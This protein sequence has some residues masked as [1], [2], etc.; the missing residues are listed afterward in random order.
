MDHTTDHSTDHTTTSAATR[1][2]RRPP[3]GGFA[4]AAVDIDDTLLG[5]D[6]LISAENAAAVRQLRERGVHVVLASGRSHA[7]MRPFHDALGLGDGPIISAQGA[8]VRP[9]AG[10]A[11]WLEQVLDAAL[12]ERVT[13]QGIERGFAVQHYRGDE[14]V[15]QGRTRWTEFDQALNDTAQQVVEDLLGEPFTGVEKVIW[16]GEPAD[17]AAA[18]AELAPVYEGRMTV[19]VTHSAYLEFYDPRTSKA[20]GLAVVAERLGV[21]RARVLAFGDGNNDVPML[22]WAGVGVAM[23]HARP[24]AQRVADLVA[25][26]GDPESSLARAV[27]LVMDGAPARR[28]G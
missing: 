15:V 13:R 12:V 17:V 23:D 28:A 4:L 24:E 18:A 25:P 27:R 5:P 19:T 14:I 6:G 20:A 8:L 26:T 10:G 7:N 9:A 21:E 11:A 16:L 2:P 3:A 1:P 22:A